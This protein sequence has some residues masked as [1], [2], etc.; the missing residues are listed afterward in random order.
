[1]GVSSFEELYQAD[2]DPWSF[3]SS[4]YEQRRYDLTIASLLQPRYRRAVEPGCAIGELTRRLAARCDAVEAF[5]G[6]PTAV[7]DAQARCA[8]FP[9]VRIEVG[10]LPDHWPAGPFDLVVLS[11]IGYYFT[12]PGLRAVRDRAIEAL[13]PA[14]TLVAVHWRG[15]SPDHVLHGDDVHRCLAAA[16]GIEPKGHYEDDGFALDL[17]TRR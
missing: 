1:V 4:H 3:A 17:W 13:E 16:T 5:D 9:H 8:A 14:G 15:S 11:E 2:A 10:E 7:R 6:A 12:L